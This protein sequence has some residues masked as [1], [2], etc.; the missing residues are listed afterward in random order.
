VANGLNTDCLVDPSELR[1]YPGNPR[2]GDLEAIKDS[3]R[4]HGQYRPIVANRG[5]GEVLAGNHL[6]LAARELGFEQLAVAFVDVDHEQA[7]RIVAVDNRTSD[8]ASYDEESLAALLSS[9][10]T[11]RGPA[12]PRPISRGCS[13]S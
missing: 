11:W 4:R 1:L 7:K 9:L 5:T 12:T 8:L 3:L 2:R 13:T 10:P 6:L